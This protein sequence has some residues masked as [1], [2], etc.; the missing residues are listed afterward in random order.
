MHSNIA[1]L[2][3]RS[4]GKG[5]EVLQCVWIEKSRF[6]FCGLLRLKSQ[7]I[8]FMIVLFLKV[9][10]RVHQWV[11]TLDKNFWDFTV[12]LSTDTEDLFQ[13]SLISSVM[14]L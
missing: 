10:P 4:P 6:S 11:C 8:Y 9:S 1:A 5:K 7:N 13:L 14:V 12:N 3:A 2:T